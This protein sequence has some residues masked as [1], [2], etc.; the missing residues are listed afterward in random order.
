M[1]LKTAW[2][3]SLTLVLINKN[4]PPLISPEDVRLSRPIPVS[5]EQEQA[6]SPSPHPNRAQSCQAGSSSYTRGKA[7]SDP[8]H[9][10]SAYR[11]GEAAPFRDRRQTPTC[12]PLNRRLLHPGGTLEPPPPRNGPAP[13]R[14]GQAQDAHRHPPW[15]PSPL[16]ASTER[17]RPLTAALRAVPTGR[18]ATEPPA[19][20]TAAQPPP[21]AAGPLCL[22]A[23][24]T[25]RGRCLPPAPA[26]PLA[27]RSRG[28]AG[29]RA[30]G[31]ARAGE[32][33]EKMAGGG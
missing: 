31:A 27:P 28:A 32:A 18:P 21:T 10:K 20:P 3:G 13:D 29:G 5:L 22:V 4:S 14:R 19:R 7:T 17:G 26:P 30:G 33:E 24:A 25:A 23:G 6:G 12:F 9:L 8:A 11:L 16:P 2:P 1:K 15:G